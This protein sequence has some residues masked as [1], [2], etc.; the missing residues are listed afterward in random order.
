M[1]GWKSSVFLTFLLVASVSA[2]GDRG[3]ESIRCSDYP[4]GAKL[5]SPV[6]KCAY[7]CCL[8]QDQPAQ[9]HKCD[10]GG[11]FDPSTKQC[12]GEHRCE[13]CAKAEC[14]DV[15]LNFTDY[16]VK[17]PND[18]CSYCECH[19]NGPPTLKHCPH[20]MRWDPVTGFCI[21]DPT[22]CPDNTTCADIKCPPN[23]GDKFEIRYPDPQNECKFCCCRKGFTHSEPMEC[24]F[25]ERYDANVDDCVPDPTKK[26]PHPDRPTLAPPTGTPPTRPSTKLPP[27]PPPY[28]GCDGAPCPVDPTGAPLYPCGG[29]PQYYCQCDWGGKAHQMPCAGGTTFNFDYQVCL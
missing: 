10:H 4:P 27:N 20:G 2:F 11:E 8:D 24:P 3:C 18:I 5:P 9:Y 12:F 7:C 1:E 13:P 14:N 19:P 29:Q 23:M 15:C 25:H 17:N 21:Y 16:P 22:A 6:C 28:D 26:C